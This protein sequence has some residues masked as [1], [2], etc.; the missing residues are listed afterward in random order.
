[1]SLKVIT[2]IAL[3]GALPSLWSCQVVSGLAD[4]E[5]GDVSTGGQ[6]TGG[7]SGTGGEIGTGGDA[8]SCLV[9]WE[10]DQCSGLC[11]D[12]GDG[13]GVGCGNLMDCYLEEQCLPA[14]CSAEL[15]D[16]C[17]GN[18]VENATPEALDMARAVVD[19]L[20]PPP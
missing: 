1:M 16:V 10:N 5:V 20:C 2:R 19:C 3:F 15:D 9:G 18:K 11:G 4:L 17:G 8:A 7:S 14:T 6:A 13:V 12:P